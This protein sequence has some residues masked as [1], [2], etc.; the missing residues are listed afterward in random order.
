LIWSEDARRAID[1]WVLANG[2]DQSQFINLNPVPNRL[3]PEIYREVDVA[4]FSN[5]CE[6]GTN[7]VAMEA[8]SCGVRSIISANTG[9]ADIIEADN[10]CPLDE[11]A[12]VGYLS[13]QQLQHLGFHSVDEWG[14]SSVEQVLDGLE[15][16][17]TSDPVPETDN[18]QRSVARLTWERSIS[19]LLQVVGGGRLD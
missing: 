12:S 13:P 14:E 2:V 16:A 5:R 10:C 17:Y 8:M 6:G 4:V 9:H 15:K 1:N 11:Q 19:H 18:I 7:L 3:M